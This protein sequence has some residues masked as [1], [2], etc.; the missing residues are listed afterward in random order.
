[1]EEETQ[2]EQSLTKRQR[3]DLRKQEEKENREKSLKGEK[4]KKVLIWSA[5]GVLVVLGFW[6]LKNNTVKPATENP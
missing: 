1:M 3:K 4:I 6:W 5:I 2:N